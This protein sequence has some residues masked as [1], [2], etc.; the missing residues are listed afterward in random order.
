MP[1]THPF[2]RRCLDPAALLKDCVKLN[3]FCS[4]LEQQADQYANKDEK[5][6]NQ[7]KGWGFELFT[8]HLLKSFPLDKRVGISNYQISNE[9]D[10]TGVDGFGTGINGQPATVQVKYRQAN[11]ILT[12]NDDHLANFKAAS[13][14]TKFNVNPIPDKSGKCNM[15]IVT[16]GKELHH[17]TRDQ[18][19]PE[20]RVLNREKLR[21][22]VDDNIAFWT[23][24]QTAWKEALSRTEKS[25]RSK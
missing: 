24:F 3:T 9:D 16:T 18:M 21:V 2:L 20:V 1:L 7:Y 25:G 13:L 8:E 12:T 23:S 15:L 22:L 19:L 4:R 17:H 11:Y 5:L 14:S 6:K 10:D